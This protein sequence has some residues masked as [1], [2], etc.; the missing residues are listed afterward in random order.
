MS[1]QDV[2][3]VG[4]QNEVLERLEESRLKLKESKPHANLVVPFKSFKASRKNETCTTLGAIRAFLDDQLARLTV[5]NRVLSV[6]FSELKRPVKYFWGVH[7]FVRGVRGAVLGH[8]YLTSIG[9]LHRDISENNV[10]LARRPGEER[11]YL[12]DFDM[13]KLQEPEERTLNVVTPQSEDFSDDDYDVGRSS[14]PISEDGANPPKALRTGTI[15]YMSFNV[16]HGRKHTRFDDMESFLYVVF[17]FFFSYTG[18]L[19][20]E[21]LRDA[22]ARGF[23]QPTGSGR[24]THTRRWPELLETWSDARKMYPIAQHKDSNLAT[25]AGVTTFLNHPEVKHSLRQNWASGLQED[26]KRLLFPL[27][28]LFAN[29]RISIS[30]GLSLPRTEVEHQQFINVLDKWLK[31]YGGKEQEF[32]NCPFT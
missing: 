1:W 11:G 17:L 20:K 30:P 32:S 5:E 12:I 9:V 6:S 4:E 18:P 19:S 7:D 3:R 21:E 8:Q 27:W 24:F 28:R 26:I 13:A 23:V 16:L 2:A 14:S 10:V 25:Q 15:P 29:S 31:K 22:D